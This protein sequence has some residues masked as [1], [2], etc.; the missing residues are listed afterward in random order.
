MAVERLSDGTFRVGEMTFSSA[1][2]AFE[3]EAARRPGQ[4]SPLTGSQWSRMS[5]SSRFG[6]LAASALFLAI[7][8]PIA[9][10]VWDGPAKPAPREA[11]VTPKK[12]PL[13]FHEQQAINAAAEQERTKQIEVSCTAGLDGLLSDA[14]KL[15][16]SGDPAMASARLNPCNGISTNKAFLALYQS[17]EQQRLEKIAKFERDEKARKRREGVSIGMSKEDVLASSWGKPEK[18]NTTT[19]ARGTREQWVYG[20]HNYLYFVGETLTTIQN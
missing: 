5:N 6:A 11:A 18:V 1:E 13:P 12:E 16:Q 3:Y 7:S 9:K 8:V 2:Q 10:S 19:T 20:G 15:L 14:R 4:P 17:A